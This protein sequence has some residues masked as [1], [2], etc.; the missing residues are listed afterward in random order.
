MPKATDLLKHQLYPA[1]LVL[2]GEALYERL[3]HMDA[4]R[5]DMAV[6]SINPN[7]Y[8]I[9]RD[10]VTQVID[11][12]NEALAEFCAAHADRFAALASVALQFPDL[13]ADQLEHAMKRR[14]LRGVAIG[15]AWLVKNWPTRSFTRS[16]PKPRISERSSSSIR[17]CPRQ[18]G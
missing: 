10:L 12:Q 3:D 14:G 7:W 18:V 4:Q 2:D 9:E 8:G 16:G 5:I 6:L 15:G 1:T 13:A 17:R 11:V